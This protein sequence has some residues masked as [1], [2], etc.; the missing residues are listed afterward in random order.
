MAS[1]SPLD[2]MQPPAAEWTHAYAYLHQDVTVD[3]RVRLRAVAHGVRLRRTIH[4]ALPHC[5]EPRTRPHLCPSPVGHPGTCDGA[6]FR[7]LRA[8][9]REKQHTQI[10][11]Y[12][13]P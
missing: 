9:G 1:P 13:A 4:R 12:N 6:Y 5:C 8:R 2:L 7:M 11:A 10:Y 3:G